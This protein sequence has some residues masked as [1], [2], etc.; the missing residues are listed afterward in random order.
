MK[1]QRHTGS[2]SDVIRAGTWHK[3]LVVDSQRFARW[4]NVR[5]VHVGWKERKGRVTRRL[6]VK[7]YVTKKR[8]KVPAPE[9][10]PRT[11][12]I[13]VP[14]G[15]GLYRARRVPTDVVSYAEPRLCAN[16][17][18]WMDPVRSGAALG[19]A[20]EDYGTFTCVVADA[21]GR[22]F[23]LTAG[24]VVTDLPGDVPACTLVQPT[25][26]GA[27]APNG[28]SWFFGTSA[29]GYFGNR[30]D[31]YADYALIKLDPHRSATTAA[32]DGAAIVRVVLPPAAVRASQTPVSKFGA[33]TGR[34]TGTFATHVDSIVVEGITPIDVFEFLGDEASP[35]AD[36]GDS[37]ALVVSTAAASAGKI[38]G[39]L[40][41]ADPPTDGA[42]GGRGYVVPFARVRGYSPV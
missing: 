20:G 28:R 8:S 22:Q 36:H 11:T 7:L 29:G 41:A 26:A 4:P 27:P 32:L 23:G 38:I 30:A 10:L 3:V 21:T 1:T 14:I 6:A 19:I 5:R 37:G 15:R 40:F 31:G 42:P 16:P 25:E 17:G 18:D 13:L 12:Q 33:K 2:V 35:F 9:R 24:H 39:I 34:T